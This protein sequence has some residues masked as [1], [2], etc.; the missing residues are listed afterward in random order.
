LIVE[1][2]KDINLGKQESGES[3]GNRR[4]HVPSLLATPDKPIGKAVVE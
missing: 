4:L 2:D 1:R 3:N